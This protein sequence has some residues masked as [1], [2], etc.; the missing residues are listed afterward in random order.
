MSLNS[1]T[2][3]PDNFKTPPSGNIPISPDEIHVWRINFENINCDLTGHSKIISPEEKYR[4]DK[5]HFEK[6]K[7][8][9]IIRHSILRSVLGRY[10]LRKP[11]SIQFE[12]NTHGKPAL[13]GNLYNTGIQFNLSHS[14]NLALI[15]IVLNREIGIDIEH[16]NA[17]IDY[18]NIAIQ[19][20][21]ENEISELR[22]LPSQQQLIAFY[23]C[24]TRKEAYIKALGQGLAIPLSTFDVTLTP[25]KPAALLKTIHQSLPHNCHSIANIRPHLDYIAAAVVPGQIAQVKYWGWDK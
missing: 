25:N 14:N 7:T 10:L 24:W 1:N 23:N 2:P 20:F 17:N 9:F 12:Y 15:A 16:I 11:E 19:Y 4:A 21:S 8:R 6:D 13:K 22:S 3:D 5:F 18:E